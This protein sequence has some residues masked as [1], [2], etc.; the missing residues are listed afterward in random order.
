MQ[1]ALHLH[2]RGRAQ[3]YGCEERRQTKFIK[4]DYIRNA[5]LRNA[6]SKATHKP[7]PKIGIQVCR[8]FLI[9]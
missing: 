3:T 9:G 8:I 4:I 1:T 5:E 2:M 7:G 6:K